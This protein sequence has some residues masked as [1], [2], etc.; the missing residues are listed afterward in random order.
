MAGRGGR[1]KPAAEGTL[2]VKQI[3]SGIG[4]E[5]NQKETLRSLGLRKINQ[6]VELPDNPAVR[7]MIETVRHLVQV[8]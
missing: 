2:K 4:F 3:R 1:A 8:V 5:R 7:G 6:V